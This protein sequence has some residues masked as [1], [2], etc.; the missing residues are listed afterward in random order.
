M[1]QLRVGITGAGVIG[2]IH[3]KALKDIPEITA[4]GITDVIPELRVRLAREHGLEAYASQAEMI[5]Q[6][7]LDYVTICT[8]HQTHAELAIAAMESG[9]HAFVEKPITVYADKAREIIAAANRTGMKLGVNFLRR[10]CPVN[11]KLKE[12]MTQGFAG[13]IKRVTVVL[14]EWFRSMFYYRSS[15]WRATW[16]GEGG[17]VLVNQAPH[18]LDL[19]VRLL[20][21]PSAVCAELSA[22][23]HDIEVEDDVCALLKWP[24]GFLGTLQVNTN[25]A[26]GRT[27]LEITGTKGTL[28]LEGTK[29]TAT[30]LAQDSREFSDTTETTMTPP[31][32]A[33]TMTYTLPDPAN[34]YTL[35]HRNFADVLC[36]KAA[37]VCPG[38]DALAEVELANALLVSGVRREWADAP[39]APA[40]FE[41]VM[42]ALIATKSITAAREKLER[43]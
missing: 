30:R 26:P 34:R 11:V 19:L 5:A 4:V 20:G 17:G 24:G 37:P 3:L 43:E 1:P 18:N 10:I 31:A 41:R 29:L 22:T 23:G 7:K 35:M 15:S 12:L 2:D 40:E 39:V 38:D 6:A 16:A 32:T 21:L 28:L 9:V 42:A 14:T 25:E 33:E 13:E 27:F 8:P 36:R